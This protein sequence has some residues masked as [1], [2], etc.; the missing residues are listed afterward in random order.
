MYLIDST[1]KMW[2]LSCS[3]LFPIISLFLI[4]RRGL[5]QRKYNVDYMIE[6]LK[7]NKKCLVRPI[8]AEIKVAILCC[9]F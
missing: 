7:V 4:L 3:F 8:L 1:F 2:S 6:A 5:E 9:S